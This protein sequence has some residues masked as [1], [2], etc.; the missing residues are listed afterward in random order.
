MGGK[1]TNQQIKI[2]KKERKKKI[3]KEKKSS[4]RKRQ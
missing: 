2:Q 3:K 1:P 4:V